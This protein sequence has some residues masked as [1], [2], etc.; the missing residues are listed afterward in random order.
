MRLN[1]FI[2]SEH[3]EEAEGSD[4]VLFNSDM[5]VINAEVTLGIK[6]HKR[7]LFP[8]DLFYSAMER[9]L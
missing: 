9:H 1:I 3:A 4:I 5:T 8:K 6:Y 7:L 2:T